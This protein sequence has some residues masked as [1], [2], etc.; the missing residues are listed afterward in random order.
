[1]KKVLAVVI[2]SALCVAMVFTLSGCIFKNPVDKLNDLLEK[3][4][5]KM[6]M[7]TS[8]IEMKMEVDG[9]ILRTVAMGEETYEVKDGDTITTYYKD[10][11]DEWAT[12]EEEFDEDDD[13]MD[14]V[15][16]LDADA[17]EKVEKGKYELVDDDL[18]EEYELKEAVLKVEKKEYELKMESEDGMEMTVTFSD[19]GDVK[20]EVPDVD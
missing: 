8:G 9:D 1:M 15:E 3:K 18:K 20:L 2:A 11:N 10:Y 13:D 19:F 7:E 14:F 17:W 16:L 4:N 5:F 12:S 6:V